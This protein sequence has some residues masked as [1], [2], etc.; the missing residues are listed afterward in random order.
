MK[1]DSYDFLPV[2]CLPLP[3]QPIACDVLAQKYLQA[4]ET[5]E[6]E[7]FDRVA[8]AL[9]SAESPELRVRWERRFRS[10]LSAG[11]IGAGRIMR[12]AGAGT[13][14]TL[15]NCFVQPLGD[16]ILGTDEQGFPGICEAL[17]ESAQTLRRG[18][19]VGYDFSRLRPRGALVNGSGSMASGPCSFI[20]LFDRSGASVQGS[21]SRR[22]AQM[23]VL[24]IDHPD[25]RE[26]I[27]AKRT[28]GRWSQF[29]VSVAVTDA[30]MH[31][32][33]Q[34]ASWALVHMARPCED[35]C[36]HGAYRRADGLW[37]YET[38]SA[39]ELWDELLQAAYDVAEPG[40]LFLDAINRDNNLRAIEQI[41]ATNPCGEQPLPPYGGCDLGPIILTRFVVHPFG[42]GGI[43]R[44]DFDTFRSCIAVQ[45][46]ALDNVLDVT[47]WPLPAQ[48]Q[49]ALS[50]RRIG[51]GFT[52]LGDAFV[53]LGLRYDSAAGRYMAA[54]IAQTMRDTAYRASVELAIV[55]APFPLFAADAYLETGTFASRLPRTIQ[56]Y[57]REHGIRN[58]H[59]LS[60]APTGSVSLAF[61]DN[62]SSGIEP[63]FA[64]AYLRKKQES[65]GTCTEYEV[66]DHAWRL[67][68]HLMGTTTKL[69]D[70]FVTALQIDPT[71]HLAM[72]QAVQPYID[73]AISKTVN[74]PAD[75]P[76]ENFQ[77]LYRQAWHSGLKGL[78]TYRPNDI[79]K[80]VLAHV[81]DNLPDHGVGRT[82]TG[83]ISP[84]VV[85]G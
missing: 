27:R 20:D 83:C 31:A 35:L 40:V 77:V 18:G 59:L 10:N 47:Q 82:R 12:A 65:D 17:R 67:Y 66:Q 44:F 79:R 61:A 5:N 19:G 50:K 46:R 69:P 53:M 81:P 1:R 15:I 30:F 4:G 62:V 6:S 39:T 51:V 26:F 11:A 76:F 16:S 33:E 28:P 68:R 43:P 75:Y 24:R 56:A 22:G 60:I 63:A 84:I 34:G 54:R 49:E 32:V 8:Q 58:S 3:P 21:G 73:S 37:V 78:T 85:P 23:G 52:G 14:D 2:P 36:R 72:M 64:W 70:S 42:L 29:T 55:K 41:A 71:D 7:I 48:Q 45:V 80:W 57:I 25:V 9:A 38:V 13:E 74:V